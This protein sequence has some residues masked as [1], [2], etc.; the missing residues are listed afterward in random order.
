MSL[1]AGRAASMVAPQR[2]SQLCE[3]PVDDGGSAENQLSRYL[4]SD[5]SEDNLADDEDDD[6]QY[7]RD[8]VGEE[9]EEGCIFFCFFFSQNVVNINVVLE[10][11]SKKKFKNRKRKEG[12]NVSTSN[13]KKPRV[14]SKSGP[15]QKVERKTG[16][17]VERKSGPKREKSNDRKAKHSDKRR[18]KEPKTVQQVM[19]ERKRKKMKQKSKQLQRG[20]KRKNR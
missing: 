15:K 12:T 20:M 9:P 17:K 11:F 18:D 10:L 8:E 2:R 19:L 3:R 5:D 6:A 7:F 16:P 14:E 4:V 1:P 13:S